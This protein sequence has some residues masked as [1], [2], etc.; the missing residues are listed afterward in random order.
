[1]KLL[2]V[3]NHTCGNRGDSAILR[4]LIDSIKNYDNAL[5]IDILSRYPISSSYLLDSILTQDILY[6]ENQMPANGFI[7]KIK[8]KISQKYNYQILLAHVKN[9]GIF[10]FFTLPKI[11]KEQI[12]RIKDYDVIIQVGGSFFVDLYG[13]GQFEHALCA[14]YANKPIYMIGHSVGPFRN[15]NFNK[16]SSYIFSQVEALILREKISL[17]FMREAN[18]PENK[19]AQGVDTAWLVAHEN[20]RTQNFSYALDY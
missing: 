11:Y 15:E 2:I 3:G 9:E 6:A 7:N 1:M 13:V 14:L 19:V 8:K 10:K 4:G 20:S 17:D 16:V 18:I 5:G 12:V